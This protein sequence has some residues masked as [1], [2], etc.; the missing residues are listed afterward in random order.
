MP[1][2]LFVGTLTRT[3][4]VTESVLGAELILNSCF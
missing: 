2:W 4:D 1:S 3:G